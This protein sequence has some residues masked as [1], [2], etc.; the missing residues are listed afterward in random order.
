MK[1]PGIVGGHCRNLWT[2]TCLLHFN[3]VSAKPAQN[4][5]GEKSGKR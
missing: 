1:Y 5:P 2:K 3:I 4:N